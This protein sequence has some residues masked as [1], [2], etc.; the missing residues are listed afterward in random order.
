MRVGGYF[1]SSVR[2]VGLRF[3]GVRFVGVTDRGSGEG[4]RFTL[5]LSEISM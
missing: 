5:E 4:S 3:V 2:F 1:G